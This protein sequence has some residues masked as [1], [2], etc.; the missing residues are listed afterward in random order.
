MFSLKLYR[1]IVSK[2]KTTGKSRETNIAFW[3]KPKPIKKEEK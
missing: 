2:I 1:N 3:P